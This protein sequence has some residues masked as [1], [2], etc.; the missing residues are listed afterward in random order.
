MTDLG[1]NIQI[2]TKCATETTDETR[3]TLPPPDIRIRNPGAMTAG[4][5][6]SQFGNYDPGASVLDVSPTVD[7]SPLGSGVARIL[8]KSS[9]LFSSS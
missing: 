9:T 1:L 3:I 6:P 8:T 5:L 7:L 4:S 2:G